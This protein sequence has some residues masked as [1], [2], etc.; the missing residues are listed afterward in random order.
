MIETYGLPVRFIF[1]WEKYD[2][3]V[4]FHDLSFDGH[5]RMV[6]LNEVEDEI[7]E[8]FYENKPERI[9][10]LT[11]DGSWKIVKILEAEDKP[12]EVEDLL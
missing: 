7:G 10:R 6:M 2:Y 9:V 1:R 11:E 3:L 12:I 8:P 5:P 4:D